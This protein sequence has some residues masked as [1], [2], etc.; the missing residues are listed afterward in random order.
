M[1]VPIAAGAGFDRSGSLYKL[2]WAA[3]GVALLAIGC[4]AAAP[5]L[6][7]ERFTPAQVECLHATALRFA[8]LELALLAAALLA[9]ALGRKLLLL[10]LIAL[11]LG[12]PAALLD[13]TAPAQLLAAPSPFEPLVADAGRSYRIDAQSA[14]LR[15]Q[16][17]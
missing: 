13:R 2:R 9:I 11:E 15:D 10:P 1:A 8:P 17:L 16:D 5:R 14:G 12:L 4:F 3:L 6:P 7:L